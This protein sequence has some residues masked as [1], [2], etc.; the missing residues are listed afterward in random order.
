MIDFSTMK[1]NADEFK[2]Y[3]GI[4]LA[5]ALKGGNSPTEIDRWLSRNQENLNM[6]I[7]KMNVQINPCYPEPTS[8]QK[9]QYKLALLEQDYY[10]FK[11]GDRIMETGEDD[12]G[13]LVKSHGDINAISVSTAAYNHLECAGLANLQIGGRGGFSF[14]WWGLF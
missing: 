11:S 13:R 12:S 6:F 14:Y 8:W 5:Q 2:E 3:T 9:K 4:D 10:V 1:V 7:A